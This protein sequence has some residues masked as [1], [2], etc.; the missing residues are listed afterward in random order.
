MAVLVTKAL[1]YA[2]LNVL[3]PAIELFEGGRAVIADN[4]R[5]RGSHGWLSVAVFFRHGC[6]IRYCLPV[7]IPEFNRANF[8]REAYLSETSFPKIHAHVAMSIGVFVH[9]LDRRMLHLGHRCVPRVCFALR[10]QGVKTAIELNAIPNV[11]IA[12]FLWRGCSAILN[13]QIKQRRRHTPICSRIL[14]RQSARRKGRWQR[15]TWL[16]IVCGVHP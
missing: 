1:Q 6:G 11:T 14:T 7:S 3:R 12:Q 13:Q 16:V 15:M 10:G 4:Q 9:I 8:R 5:P 2:P